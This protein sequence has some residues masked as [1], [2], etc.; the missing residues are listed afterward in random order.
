M[1]DLSRLNQELQDNLARRGHQR[2]R[3]KQLSSEHAFDELC[4]WHGLIGWGPTLR[5]W[6][7]HLKDVETKEPQT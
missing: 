5:G 3:I 2:E 6:M 7:V 4:N 1:L